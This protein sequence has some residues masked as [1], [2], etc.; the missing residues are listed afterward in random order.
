VSDLEQPDFHHVTKAN[1][2]LRDLHVGW[3][4]KRAARQYAFAY[5]KAY[6]AMAA[7]IPIATSFPVRSQEYLATELFPF[8]DNL[9]L[10]GWLLTQAEKLLHIDKRNR[11]ALL[12]AVGRHTI[13]AVAVAPLDSAG[14]ELPDLASTAPD[15]EP[16]I[17]HELASPYAEAC[18]ACLL[19]SASGV[20]HL[21]CR[22]ELWGTTKPVR[23]ALDAVD[24]LASFSKTIHG[25]SISGAQRKGLF[26]FDTRAAALVPTAAGASFLLKP[27]GDHPELP[28]N[29]HLTMAIARQLKFWTPPIA[30]VDVGAQMGRIYV[31]KRFDR[32]ASGKLLKE[33]AA[34]LLGIPSEEKYTTSNERVGQA[35]AACA[36]KLDLN[37][38]FRRLV[39]CF[40]IGNGDMHL[41][42]WALIEDESQTG[43]M[44]LSPCYD[45][46]NTR[47]ALP[48][49]SI[50]IG[51]PLRGKTRNLQGSY[52]RS[53]AAE[54]L[55][56][57][58]RF[59][60]SVFQELPSWRATIEDFV[61]RSALKPQSKERYLE[62]VD[63]RLAALA[64]C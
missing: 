9:I 60:D 18:P 22:K 26:R 43:A 57:P 16:L 59:I 62:I 12:M 14:V 13:G 23:L 36:T 39:F 6:A 47:L 1:V 38:F 19:P 42:N 27:Q 63:A 53:F 29:E 24:P 48:R 28:E 61:P 5:T 46:L 8:F 41:K 11:F 20:Y 64:T 49:E 2:Y 31:I 52:F 54:N 17:H 55:K 35:L 51:L 21:R 32:R 25:G 4:E 7:A 50:D 45:L 58:P 56:L 10:E 3:L 15:T 30:L 40:A 33:D 34:Q 37:D 44:R